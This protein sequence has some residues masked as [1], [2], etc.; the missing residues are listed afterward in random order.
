MLNISRV[1]RDDP[2][3][4]ELPLAKWLRGAV[5]PVRR[6]RHHRFERPLI[7]FRFT[8]EEFILSVAGADDVYRS[9]PD[10]ACDARSN[11]VVEIGPDARQCASPTVIVRNAFAS[12]RLV[13]GD[14]DLAEIAFRYT[15]EVFMRRVGIGLPFFMRWMKPRLLIH[16]L[17]LDAGRISGLE[18]QALID[19]GRRAGASSAAVYLGAELSDVELRT[20]YYVTARG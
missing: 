18:I 15:Y 3:A 8:R 1:S 10:I 9:T 2:A 7:Y 19:L 17:H 16:P 5:A 6:V 12:D 20:G 11:I 14:V 4:R 13:F